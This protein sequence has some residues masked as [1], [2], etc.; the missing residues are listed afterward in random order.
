M[1][2]KESQQDLAFQLLHLIL[3]P[4][5]YLHNTECAAVSV[6]PLINHSVSPPP[7]LTGVGSCVM[8]GVQNLCDKLKNS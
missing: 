6:R 5:L 8:V 4:A 7:F 3:S 2:G 1:I